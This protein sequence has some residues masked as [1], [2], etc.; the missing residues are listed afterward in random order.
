MLS[1]ALLG[2]RQAYD[3]RRQKLGCFAKKPILPV[4]H[5][6]VVAGD[7]KYKG[8]KPLPVEF[9]DFSTTV[10]IDIDEIALSWRGN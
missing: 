7:M 5:K 2:R 6:I 3:L 8:I 9:A 10:F 1:A 4:N